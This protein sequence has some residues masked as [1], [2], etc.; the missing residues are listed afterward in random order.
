MGL[1]QVT[2]SHRIMV[3]CEGNDSQALLACDLQAGDEVL[4]LSGL[5]KLLAISSEIADVDVLAITFQPDKAVAV[6]FPPDAI[7]T[8]GA[9]KKQVRRG[10]KNN[11]EHFDTDSDVGMP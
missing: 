3:P 10:I 4:C 6:F 1:L 7:L 2:P 11:F 9:K 5:Q 8:K